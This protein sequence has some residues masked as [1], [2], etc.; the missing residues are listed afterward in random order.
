VW[1]HAG[2]RTSKPCATADEVNTRRSWP[3]TKTDVIGAVLVARG[4]LDARAERVISE[5]PFE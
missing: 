4:H 3:A 2:T 1:V 5:V